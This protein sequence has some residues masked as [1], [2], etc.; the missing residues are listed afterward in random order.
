[1]AYVLGYFAADGAMIRNSRG[2]HFIEFHSIDKILITKVR[3]ALK[4]SHHIGVRVP[5]KNK[6]NHKIAYRLQIGSVEI[7]NDLLTL[8][9]SPRKSLTLQMPEVPQKCIGHF[10]RGYFDG[11]GNIYFKKHVVKDRKNPRYVFATRFTCGSRAFLAALLLALKKHGCRR[12]FILEKHHT[13]YELIFSHNDSV[14]LYSIMY[15]NIA[16]SD[17]YLGRKYKLFTHALET[18]YGK[19]G[20]SSAS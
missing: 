17:I 4:S 12:G 5:A 9:M 20:S 14:A 13:A 16:D 10:V 6:P 1:M 2:A 7:Y 18:L 8:G 19:C 3:G 15:N 11:D